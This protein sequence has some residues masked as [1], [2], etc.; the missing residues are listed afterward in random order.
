MIKRKV[1]FWLSLL[2]CIGKERTYK[3]YFL[4]YY[5]YAITFSQLKNY[6]YAHSETILIL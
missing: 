4:G 1:E 6:M 2:L 3:K 5:K